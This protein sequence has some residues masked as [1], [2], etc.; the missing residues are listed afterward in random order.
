MGKNRGAATLLQAAITLLPTYDELESQQGKRTDLTS[1]EPLQ[2]LKTEVYMGRNT[3]ALVT[4]CYQWSKLIT[5]SQGGT[6]FFEEILT[7]SQ[8]VTRLST[9]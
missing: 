8:P 7:S 9:D 1:V 4:S 5:S 2:K 6:K 3:I